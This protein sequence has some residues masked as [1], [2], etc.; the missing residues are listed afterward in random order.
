MLISLEFVLCWHFQAVF[1]LARLHAYDLGQC[2]Q[3]NSHIYRLGTGT[4]N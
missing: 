4:A 2:H 1:F 3:A